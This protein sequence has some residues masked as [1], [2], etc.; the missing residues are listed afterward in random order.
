LANATRSAGDAAPLR[1]GRAAV[2]VLLLTLAL[3]VLWL[4]CF[5]VDPTEPVDAEGYHLLAVNL[6]EGRG[7]AIGW[8]A[9]FCPTAV[10][11]PFYPAFLMLAYATLGRD[12]ARAVLLQLLL[13][14]LTTALVLRMARDLAHRSSLPVVLA[15][16]LYALNGTTQRYTGYLLAECLLLPVVTAAFLVAL[17]CLR[18]PSMPRLGL[19]AALWASALLVK[20]NLQYLALAVG[21]LL[22]L[23]L[24]LARTLGSRPLRWA[25][26][27]WA[28]LLLTLA[29]WLLRNRLLFGRWLLSTAFEENLAR[30]S[31]TAIRAQRLD[32]PVEPWTETWEYLYTAFEAEVSRRFAWC[33]RTALQG[34]CVELQQRQRQIAIAAREEVW[35]HLPELLR[36]H[37]RGVLWSILD[38]GHRTWYRALTGADWESTGVAGRLDQ[39]FAWSLERGAPGDALRAFWLERCVRIPAD[40][41][42]IWWLLAGARLAVWILGLRGLL[43]LRPD[44]WAALLFSGAL[45]YL[46]LLPGP[47]AYDRFYLP[48]VPLVAVLLS[49][50]RRRARRSIVEKAERSLVTP[51]SS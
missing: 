36:A 23:R 25:C 29:P 46:I 12:P 35:T 19:C 3:R 43:R 41:A 44:P 50:P 31:V 49:T 30:V 32:S 37:L 15:G 2:L 1:L 22:T 39:R 28:V 14:V 9:P 7:F 40:A 11:T 21:V 38:P 33:E 4:Q 47:I 10:R 13:E 24:A 5:P 16:L 45:A 51:S 48:A 6:R 27:F 20:P 34:G 17:R 42:A 18:R 26:L 8:E